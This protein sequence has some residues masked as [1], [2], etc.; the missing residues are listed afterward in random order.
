MSGTVLVI[1]DSPELLAVVAARL[2]PEGYRV[3]TSPDW[4]YGLEQAVSEQPD[5][6]LLDVDMPDQSGLDVCRRLK[7]D[8]R[9][10]AIPVIFLTAHDDVNVKVDRKSVV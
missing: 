7:S 5:L 6:V 10:S 2:K 4:L 1:D 8:P 3:L 9:T